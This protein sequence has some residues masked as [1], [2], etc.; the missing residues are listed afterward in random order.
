[1][2]PYEKVCFV[3]AD[4]ISARR[5]IMRFLIGF[6]WIQCENTAFSAGAVEDAGSYDY[7]ITVST[8]N[9]AYART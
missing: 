2:P 6:R 9:P 4:S 7:T 3:G 5:Y 8:E 1:M